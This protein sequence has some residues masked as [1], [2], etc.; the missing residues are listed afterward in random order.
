MLHK[1]VDRFL[2]GGDL[3]LLT[4][5]TQLEAHAHALDAGSPAKE[6]AVDR[7]SLSQ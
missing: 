7:Y 2:K 1:Q 3:V 6:E 4:V 5:S